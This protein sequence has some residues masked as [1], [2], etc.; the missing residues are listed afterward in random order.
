MMSILSVTRAPGLP[1]VYL[2]VGLISL[3]VGWMFYL[4]PYLARAQGA[5]ARAAR[6]DD[7]TRTR[8]TPAPS[9]G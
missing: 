6:A 3:G 9:L 4:K 7:P 5:R 2:G 1:L 8:G